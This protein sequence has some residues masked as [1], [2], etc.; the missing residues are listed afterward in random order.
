[1]RPPCRSPLGLLPVL[2]V[3]LLGAACAGGTPAAGPGQAQ[4]VAPAPPVVSPAA[5]GAATLAAP[6]PPAAA[7]DWP[8]YHRDAARTGFDPGTPPVSRPAGAWRARTDAAVYA[9][10]LVVG[11]L[12][13]AAS[14]RNTVYGFE[15]TTG[16]QRWSRQLGPPV[17]RSAL[18]CGNIDPLGITGT[19]AYDAGTRT[20]FVVTTTPD[21]PRIRHTLVGLDPRTGAVRGSRP[22]DPPGQDPTVENQRGALAVTA[23]HV[24]VPYGG[25]LGDCGDFHGYV[26]G[27]PTSLRGDLLVNRAGARGEAGEWAAGGVAVDAEGFAYVANGNGRAT[28]GAYD[29][30]DAVLKLDPR[31]GLRQ[32][33][34]LGERDWA[35]ANAADRDLGSASPLLVAGYVWQQGKSDKSYLRPQRDLGGLQDRPVT[36]GACASQFG[37][38]AAHGSVLFASCTDGVRAVG[39]LPAG[40]VRLG[41][42]APAAVNGSPVV[43]GGAVWALDVRAG[44]LHALAEASGRD[45]GVVDVGDVTRFATPALSGGFALVPTTTGVTAVRVAS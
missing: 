23:G 38:A 29:G 7:T 18:P 19:P 8:G 4:S 9:A 16:R 30:S 20:L 32:V 31:R 43:G 13:V 22:A 26:V 3:L 17:P 2:A 21:G 36:T 39:V 37:G 34:F 6:A 10:P 1:M 11:G 5:P 44:R 45:L 12:V 33:D 40:G 28:S 25:H 14:E 27:V 42:K 24:L 15:L 35:D 41:W